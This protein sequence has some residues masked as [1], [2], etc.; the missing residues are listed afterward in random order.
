M[1]TEYVDIDGVALDGPAWI[2]T[3]HSDLMA[4]AAT[5][6]SNRRLPRGM[7]R[8]YPRHVTETERELPMVIYGD[9]APDGSPH[10]D[11]R[12]GMNLNVNSLLAVV[13]PLSTGDGTRLA[14]WH[15]PTGATLSARVQTKLELGDR[16]VALLRA[17]LVL[18]LPDGV[19][20]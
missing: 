5:V 2:V 7:V 4:P 19:F 20:A 17:I 12:A 6:G 13:G 11:H 15:L 9:V 8:S 1:A 16:R 10:L 14:T 3:N 18:T